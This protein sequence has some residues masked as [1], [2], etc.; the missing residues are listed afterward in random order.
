[1]SVA[2]YTTKQLY[3]EFNDP[4]SKDILKKIIVSSEYEAKN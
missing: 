3:K 2:S 1:M 4:L